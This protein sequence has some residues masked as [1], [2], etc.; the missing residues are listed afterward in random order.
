MSQ[1]EE[2]KNAWQAYRKVLEENPRAFLIDGDPDSSALLAQLLTGVGVAAKASS[3]G[4]RAEAFLL[5]SDVHVNV[6]LIDEDVPGR[7][8]LDVIDA[9]KRGAP[10]VEFMFMTSRPQGE[11][12]RQALRKGVSDF[13]VKPIIC[14]YAA[15][16]KITNFIR[17]QFDALV[18][19]RMVND[20]KGLLQ[21]KLEPA[22]RTSVVE[23]LARSLAVFRKQLEAQG[24]RAL[25]IDAGDGERSAI[26]SILEKRGTAVV[27][28]NTADQARDFLGMMN[29][30][31]VV[32]PADLPGLPGPQLAETVRSADPGLEVVL[33]ADWT[34][35]A[36][37]LEAVEGG[38]YGYVERPFR[39]P[40]IVDGLL[41]RALAAQ[42]RRLLMTHLLQ[43]LYRLSASFLDLSF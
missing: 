14:G 22:K 15:A 18:N 39:V 8:A 12:L 5:R 20:L 33:V 10:S 7:S 34:C 16:A 35:L 2:L 41:E 37:A 26:A 32:A 29:F 28:A 23:D 4:A 43:E 13:L 3:D 42:R 38:V 31:L 11:G 6:V 1:S 9:V 19:E 21:E 24:R 30:D 27:E 17:R 40:E 25:V 36:A